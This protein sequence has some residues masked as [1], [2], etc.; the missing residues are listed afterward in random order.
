M[1]FIVFELKTNQVGCDDTNIYK[2]NDSCFNEDGSLNEKYLSEYG[3]E[4][5]R[6]NAEMYGLLDEALSNGLDE[7]EC[8]Y[9][10][11]K[12]VEF[13][14]VEEAEEEYGSVYEF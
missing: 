1:K 8:Y 2:A 6:D 10:S 9:V 14:S 4:L 12:L 11:F 3:Y 5:A 13:N 7:E